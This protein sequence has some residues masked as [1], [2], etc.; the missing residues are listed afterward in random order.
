[1]PEQR[2]LVLANGV[3]ALAWTRGG[4]IQGVIQ[5]TLVDDAITAITVTADVDRIAQFDVVT[6][7]N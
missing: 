2:G 1:M 7:G 3:A 5:F 6:L 4:Q